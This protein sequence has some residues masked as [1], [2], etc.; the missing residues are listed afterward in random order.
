MAQEGVAF[1]GAS[2][3]CTSCGAGLDPGAN[4][5]PSCGTPVR[6]AAGMAPD[7]GTPYVPVRLTIDGEFGDSLWAGRLILNRL[8]LFVKWLSAI[9][10]YIFMIFYGIFTLIV[11]FVA[12]WFILFTGRFPAG[13]FTFVR[14]FV[15]YEYRVL[16]YF[17]L[18]L[19]N[20]WAPNDRHPLRIE[21]DYPA[22]SY[23]RT[24]LLF[25]KLPSFLLSVVSN[26][27]GFSLIITFLLSIPAWWFILFTGRYPAPWFAFIPGMLEWNCRI[28]VWQNLMRGDASLSGTTTPVKVVAGIGL[29]LGLIAT[30]SEM[31]DSEL[32]GIARFLG[33]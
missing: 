19:T 14:G 27:A 15:Q 16:A 23:S 2:R 13:L 31:L 9:P 1:D 21:I 24:V 3:F 8:L 20:H 7:A 33:D 11:I 29:V 12:F 30:I 32:A 5:C 25:L 22:E 26:L 10:L 17:P 4:F 18:L 6:S 28:S